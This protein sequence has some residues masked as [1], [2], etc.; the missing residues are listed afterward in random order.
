MKKLPLVLLVLTLVLLPSHPAEAQKL[1][2]VHKIGFLGVSRNPT[3][4]AEALRRSLRE[5]GYG[6][7]RNI[8]IEYRSGEGR[9]RLAELAT[10][11]IREKVD[12]IVASGGPAARSAKDAT[13]TIPIVFTTSGDPIDPALRI[14]LRG[15]VEI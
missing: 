10:E 15:R 13:N 12:V 8:V 11:L 3:G 5:I 4:G 6:E 9:P 1:S 7:G 14:A 2:T